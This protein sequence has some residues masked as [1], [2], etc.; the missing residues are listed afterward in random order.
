MRSDSAAVEFEAGFGSIINPLA[1]F[2]IAPVFLKSALVVPSDV[3]PV[4]RAL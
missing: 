3:A 1:N 2:I 4:C